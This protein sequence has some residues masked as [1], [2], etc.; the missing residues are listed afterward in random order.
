MNNPQKTDAMWKV[1]QRIDG[2]VGS[3]QTKAT[4]VLAFNAFQ[5]SAIAV[6]AYEISTFFSEVAWLK[7]AALFLI[8]IS[9]VGLLV[10]TIWSLRSLLPNRS[11][12]SGRKRSHIFFM[13]IAADQNCENFTSR[14]EACSEDEFASD[15]ATQVFELSGILRSKYDRLETAMNAMVWFQITPLVLLLL[16]KIGA[17]AS[18][19]INH[20]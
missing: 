17:V 13:D 6:K 11:S 2:Y 5:G 20:Y 7:T 14:L 18:R 19:A 15:L 4:A 8:L 3:A 12:S 9:T 10:S 16:L 1:I